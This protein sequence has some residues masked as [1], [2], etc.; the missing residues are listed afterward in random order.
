ME[1]ILLAAGLS[2]RLGTGEQKAIKTY[3]GEKLIL[4]SLSACLECFDVVVVTGYRSDEVSSC[5]SDFLKNRD[6]EHN[7]R[8]VFNE[9]YE[10]GQF[11]SCMSGMKATTGDFM[12]V[13]CDTPNLDRMLIDKVYCEFK[14]LPDDIDVLRPLASSVPIHPVVFRSSARSVL[15]QWQ[16]CAGNDI[17]FG[18][19]LSLDKRLNV[20]FFDVGDIEYAKDLDY[21]DDFNCLPSGN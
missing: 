10:T 9:E 16:P 7:C 19:M 6:F 14:R 12:F 5:I 18:K 8:I 2:K 3:R 20:R 11:S 21:S 1:I 13:L 4:H 15:M 17:G